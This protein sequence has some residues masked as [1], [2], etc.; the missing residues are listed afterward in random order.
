M[1]KKLSV[2]ECK[3]VLNYYNIKNP[4][5]L[6]HIKKVA[7]ILIHTKMCY[8]KGNELDHLNFLIYT[9]HFSK[10]KYLTNN[11]K[12]YF[13]N[14]FRTTRNTSPISYFSSI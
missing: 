1:F 8:F 7:N 12:K 14:R 3:K 11:T 5:C 13:K 2:N 10:N 6:Y 9:K 4:K